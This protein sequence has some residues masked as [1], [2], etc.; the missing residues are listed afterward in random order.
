MWRRGH[1]GQ[2]EKGFAPV[3][4]DSETPVEMEAVDIRELHGDHRPA[5]ADTNHLYEM[6][7]K[8]QT[9]V[10]ELPGVDVAEQRAEQGRKDGAE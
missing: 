7:G 1:N 3:L 9:I 4:R 6:S 10:S 2:R 5:E 8:D